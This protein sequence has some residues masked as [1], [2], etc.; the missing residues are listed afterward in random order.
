MPEVFGIRYRVGKMVFLC[1]DTTKIN[2][3]I[4]LRHFI[5][6]GTDKHLLIVSIPERANLKLEIDAASPAQPDPKDERVISIAEELED[7][8]RD[9]GSWYI[10]RAREEFHRRR[11]GEARREEEEDLVQVC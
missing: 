3:P 10:G 11:M 8:F 9:D 1:G 6:P 4:P 7:D 5:G 2:V